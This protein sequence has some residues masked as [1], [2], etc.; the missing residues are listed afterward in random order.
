MQSGT[1]D[2]YALDAWK[3]PQI[4][5][6]KSDK[7]TID[8]NVGKFII[9]TITPMNNGDAVDNIIPKIGQSNIVNK[10][11][12]GLSKITTSNYIHLTVPKYLFRP[13]DIQ[14]TKSV[15]REDGY[16]TNC[17]PQAKLIY[18]EF[19]KDQKFIAISMDGSQFSMK[20]I[21]VIES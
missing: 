3:Y 21:G 4:V 16:Y 19:V 11:N 13:I 15:S 9:P 5:I 7:I 12:L 8:N 14:I 20:I 6:L 1:I 18:N 2:N 10:D 17:T